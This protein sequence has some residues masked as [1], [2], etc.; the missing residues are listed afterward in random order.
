MTMLTFHTFKKPGNRPVTAMSKTGTGYWSLKGFYLFPLELL[1]SILVGYL[2]SFIKL[3][4]YI[5]LFNFNMFFL[6]PKA[7]TE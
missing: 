5:C 6:V 7:E 3:Q 4:R 2:I 1:N